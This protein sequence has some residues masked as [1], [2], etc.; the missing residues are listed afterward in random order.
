MNGQA[1]PKRSVRLPRYAELDDLYALARREYL[2]ALRTESAF[3]RFV[4]TRVRD[5]Q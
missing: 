5:G 4:S 3:P 2:T 1:A